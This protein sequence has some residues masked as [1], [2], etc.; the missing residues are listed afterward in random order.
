MSDGLARALPLAL[1]LVV[2]ARL[3]RWLTFVRLGEP[4]K[5][6]P[7][8]ARLGVS[9]GYV[10]RFRFIRLPSVGEMVSTSAAPPFGRIMHSQT[11]PREDGGL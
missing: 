10:H 11:Q 7:F 9:R 3:V 4:P 5:V 2:R 1:A 8:G 6:A